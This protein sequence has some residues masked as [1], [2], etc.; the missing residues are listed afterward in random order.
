MSLVGADGIGR[1]QLG[2]RCHL[3]RRDAGLDERHARA[4]KVGD[5]LVHQQVCNRLG[6]LA[7]HTGSGGLKELGKLRVAGDLLGIG[8]LNAKIG[9]KTGA[10]GIGQL[11][12]LTSAAIDE[13]VVQIERRQVG[14]GEQTIVVGRLL[15][16]HDHGAL[17]AGLPVAGLLIDNAALLEH[18]GL[19]A[20]LVGKAVVQALKRV[21]VLKLGFGTQLGLAATAQRHVAVAAHRTLLHGAVRNAQRHKDATELFHK[22]AS[23]LR[24]TQVGLGDEL[25]QRRAAAVVVDE[26]LGGGGNAA[27]GTT[28]VHHLGSVLLHVDA[29]N[30]D[31][32]RVGTVLATLGHLQVGR[33]I[34]G[35]M[36]GALI[37]LA[38]GRRH[39]RGQALGVGRGARQALGLGL[40][41][42][43]IGAL[44]SAA[45][46][47]VQVQVTVHGKGDRTLRGLEVLGHIGIEVVLAVEHRV[48][49]D[50]A[51][52][53]EAGLNDALD[54]AL[55][56][57]RQGAGQAQTHRTHVGVGLVIVAEL[58]VAEHLGIE[59]GEL[60]MNLQADHGLP[61]LQD[62]GKL[63]HYSSPPFPA[64]SG[65][66]ESAGAPVAAS[67]KPRSRARANVSS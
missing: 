24:R 62:L 63:L 3:S 38:H 44:C 54:G 46:S 20:N 48:A 65:A 17:A 55:V 5:H 47:H 10:L 11:G 36:A 9:L 64:K 21:E 50:L 59:C 8:R 51:V 61:I 49:L 18:L 58:A 14:V 53:G 27:L 35:Q 30:A 19:A 57:H 22:Q 29:Q 7:S 34:A 67:A 16:T 43:A 37:A 41:K 26:R 12:N 2:K 32:H 56:G 42:R 25:D 4:L 1:Q 13:L 40:A 31:G 52:G 39:G 33:V 66:T 6:L 23:L 28:H 45:T 60:G 15:H